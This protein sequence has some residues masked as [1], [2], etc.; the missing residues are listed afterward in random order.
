MAYHIITSVSLHGGRIRRLPSIAAVLLTERMI[1]RRTPNGRFLPSWSRT[2]LPEAVLGVLLLTALGSCVTMPP[3]V[4]KLKEEVHASQDLAV[5]MQ[6]LRVR[7]RT[8]V[9]PFAAVIV[10]S[11]DRIMETSPDR[12]IQRAALLFKIQAVPAMREAL[13]RQHPFNAILDS[14]VLSWQLTDYFETGRGSSALGDAAPVAATSCRYLESQI[15]SVAASMTHSGDVSDIRAFTRR[16][17]TEHP[18]DY[19]IAGREST[20]SLVT[21]VQL[22]E[23]FSTMEVA[24]SLAIT[25]D[26]LVRRLDVYSDQLLNES[27]WQAELFV[28]DM[29]RRYHTDEVVLLAQN[30]I[31][32]A[33]AATA[34][35]NHLLPQIEA[36]L[37]AAEH[38]PDMIARE[39]AVAV[40]VFSQE[41]SRS[42]DFIRGERIAALAHMTR[43]RQEALKQVRQ[44]IESEHQRL[45]A[46][47]E[48]LSQNIVD[49]AF[50][51]AIQLSAGVLVSL[52][53]GLFMLLLAARRIFRY[54]GHKAI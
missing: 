33:D 16:W 44:V 1:T 49:Q 6:Q 29:E 32:S 42:L 19:S 39:R 53:V 31:Q 50:Q 21:E 28:M 15:E 11:A 38:A 7:M 40:D 47:M 54:S 45:S 37:A 52:F 24:G 20:V 9:E 12:N 51:R 26:D 27:R 3:P 13:F 14:W 2:K 36:A 43:E 10:A 4:A 8:L 48:T 41:I 23:T 22:Q 17:A 46:V 18:I 34:V 25:T 35:A 5:T 30:A